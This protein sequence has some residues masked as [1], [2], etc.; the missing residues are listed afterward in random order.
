MKKVCFLLIGLTMIFCLNFMIF[1]ACKQEKKHYEKLPPI[2]RNENQYKYSLE[3]YVKPFWEGTICYNESVCFLGKNAKVKLLYDAS[4][5]LYVSSYDLS[6]QYE[7]GQDF[8]YENGYLKLTK[9]TS[10]PY[11]TNSEYFCNDSN[12]MRCSKFPY[13]HMIHDGNGTRIISKQVLVSYTH[14]SS[15]HYKPTINKSNPQYLESLLNKQDAKILFFGDSI[16][17]G[18]GS[19]SFY[20]L[21][22]NIPTWTNL[23]LQYIQKF[24][25][26]TIT[27]TNYAVGG[28]NSFWGADN[29]ENCVKKQNFDIAV[30][31]FGMNDINTLNGDYKQNILKIIQTIKSYNPDCYIMLLSPMLPNSWA[32]DFYKNQKN[33]EAILKSIATTQSN[34]CLIP[35]TTL[36][37][38]IANNKNFYE[39]SHNNI[40]HPNDYLARIYAQSFL[41]ALYGEEFYVNSK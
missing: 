35:I 5:I 31:G 8:I 11:F 24:K 12:S 9:N 34:L 41:Y 14:T 7:E 19:T 40:N 1:S 39:M 33:F 26:S 25:K 17:A 37:K 22:P 15:T 32:K 30:I 38:K 27:F 29:I 23:A 10:I 2:E 21:S 28:T 6:I 13:S 36:Y 4:Q 18:A 3:T 16:V 20:C